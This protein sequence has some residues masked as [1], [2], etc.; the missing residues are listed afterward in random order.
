M[1]VKELMS[2]D[3]RSCSEDTDLATAARLMWDGDCG[4]VP[5][6]NDERRITGVIT[7]RDICI[8]A[9]TRSMSPAGLTVRDVMSRDVSTCKAEDDVR[10]ALARLKDRR[11]HRLPVV[12]RQERLVGV[13]S[14]NDFAMRAECR[15][16]AEIS[17]E[18]F[19]DAM[20]AICAHTAAAVVA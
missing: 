17:G 12:D 7:D 2:D 13:I 5:I 16:G 15:R 18:E 4:I 14:M 10:E 9:A 20:K 6:V 3:V 11:V 1:T 8:A 19:L